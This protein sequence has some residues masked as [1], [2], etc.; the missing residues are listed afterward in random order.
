MRA[1]DLIG[2]IKEYC[3]REDVEKIIVGLPKQL[4]GTP[5]ESSRYIEPF[6]RQLGREMPGMAVE[7]YDE[8]FTSAIAHRAMVEG[9]MKKTARRNKE[10]VDRMAA[11]I[12]L[13]D[14]LQ[15]KFGGGF[16]FNR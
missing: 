14:Y 6:L 8:R 13:T 12:I 7:R 3:D 16:T 2:W 9:G 11:T 4:D 1:C 15:S 10:V 5:S